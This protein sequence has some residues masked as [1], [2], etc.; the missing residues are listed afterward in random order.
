MEKG[1]TEVVLDVLPAMLHYMLNGLLMDMV[2]S[3]PVI[4]I[5]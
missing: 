2:I 4:V 3:L 5:Q 1:V